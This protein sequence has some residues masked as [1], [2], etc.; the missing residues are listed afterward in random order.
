MRKASRQDIK[1][2]HSLLAF[3]NL[4]S[5]ATE[6]RGTRH[7]GIFKWQAKKEKGQRNSTKCKSRM[8]GNVTSTR[9]SKVCNI[10][11]ATSS[12]FAVSL[13]LC[14]ARSLAG[15]QTGRLSALLLC[16]ILAQV[17]FALSAATA[18]DTL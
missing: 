4:H 18:A 1:D 9:T 5:C 16:A 11:C 14:R 10:K 17:A 8:N 3:K 6:E 7:T 2:Q 15:Q 13:S 12:A